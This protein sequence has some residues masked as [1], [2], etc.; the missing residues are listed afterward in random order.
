MSEE[1]EIRQRDTVAQKL[2]PVV[3]DFYSDLG[4]N[5]SRFV[6]EN[7]RSS[8]YQPNRL[9][10]TAGRNGRPMVNVSC[11]K[12]VGSSK[13][14]LGVISSSNPS[15]SVEVEAFLAEVPENGVVEMQHGTNGCPERRTI[16]EKKVSHSD[17]KSLSE[18]VSEAL[19]IAK[20]VCEELESKSVKELL[21]QT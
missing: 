10:V 21:L 4:S 1:V 2:L 13:F 19:E 12:P 6:P 14:F 7:F 18:T 5:W 16:M 20:N 15:G 3:K 11:Y 17:D 8:G 9:T